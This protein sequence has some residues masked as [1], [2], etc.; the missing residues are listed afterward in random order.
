MN[1][2]K[3]LRSTGTK[4]L[5]LTLILSLVIMAERASAMRWSEGLKGTRGLM[6]STLGSTAS[7]SSRSLASFGSRGTRERFVVGS[8][9]VIV[10]DS[11]APSAPISPV[12]I[13]TR[14]PSSG[15]TA[16]VLSKSSAAPGGASVNLIFSATMGDFHLGGPEAYVGMT[17]ASSPVAAT[18]FASPVAASSASLD[19]FRSSAIPTECTRF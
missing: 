4:V 8:P 14:P 16:V 2:E 1:W 3:A 9:R 13:T 18:A 5:G 7:R 17:G 10:S 11:G 19:S 15:A 6:G 12:P